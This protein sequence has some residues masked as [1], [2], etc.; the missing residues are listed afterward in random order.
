VERDTHAGESRPGL[1]LVILRQSGDTLTGTVGPD[2]NQRRAI[3]N[4]TLEGDALTGQI[5]REGDGQHQTAK[6]NLKRET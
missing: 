1:A 5:T 4:G 6:L 3:A 2:E